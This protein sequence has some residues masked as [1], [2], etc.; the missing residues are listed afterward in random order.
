MNFRIGTFTG[1]KHS[2]ETKAK[3]RLKDRSGKNNSSYG[4]IWITN[5]KL[6]KKIK[7]EDK[8]PKGFKK[9][10]IGDFKHK[11]QKIVK[12][13]NY[14]CEKCNIEFSKI[15]AFRKTRKIHC[16]NCIQKRLKSIDLSKI[17][18][19]FQ[20]STRTISKIVKRMNLSCSLCNWNECIGD[21]HHII[22]K[23]KGGSDS[24]SNLTYICP[25]CHRKAHNNLIKKFVTLEEQIGK[26]WKS[27]YN[28][29]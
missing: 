11:S 5:G 16:D 1:K 9:G 25:N 4:M 6:N 29:K 18:S 27:F 20:L 14:K 8:I 28:K 17:D 13:H 15:R 10:R 23:G 7:K 12:L 2:E 24:H 21:L 19:L 3:M 26:T 22:P